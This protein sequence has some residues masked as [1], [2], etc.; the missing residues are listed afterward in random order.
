MMSKQLLMF[1]PLPIR[2]L[3][4]I[5]FIAH[6]LPKFE[7]IAGTQVVVVSSYYYNVRLILLNHIYKKDADQKPNRGSEDCSK[8]SAD[9]SIKRFFSF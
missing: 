5:T 7:D 2:I 3:A 1:G 8:Y 9:L 6:G 4:G